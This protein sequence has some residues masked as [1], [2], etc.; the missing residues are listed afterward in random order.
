MPTILVVDDDPQIL[1]LFAEILGKGGYSVR[2]TS[3]GR[4][5][6]QLLREEPVDLV[7]LDLSMPEPDGFELLKTLRASLP[8]LRIVVVSGYLQGALLE[9]ARMLGATATL[10]KSDAPAS[11]LQTV[12]GILRGFP[13]TD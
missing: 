13:L 12:R 8:G 3:C 11:L 6:L 5:A 1:A 4:D 10:S 2:L 7:V 9:A